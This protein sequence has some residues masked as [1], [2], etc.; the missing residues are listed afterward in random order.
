MNTQPEISQL[1]WSEDQI[2][3]GVFAALE[4]RL[5]GLEPNYSFRLGRDRWVLAAL[6][7]GAGL[8]S[9]SR[10]WASNL[11]PW[12]SFVGFSLELCAL[13]VFAYRQFWDIVPDFVDAKQ[14]YA[15]ELDH[16]FK[17][18]EEIRNWLRT[19]PHGVL[20]KRIDYLESRRESMGQRY[21]I[22]FGAADRLGLLPV[23]VGVFLQ[24]QALKDVSVLMGVFAVFVIALYGMALW[25]SRFRL[26][27]ESYIRLLKSVS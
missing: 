8:V 9:T 21:P 12:V 6:V 14:K 22:L 10:L 24:I 16:H 15:S 26:Q 27:L 7:V 2:S 20:E 13:S 19:L 18:Y 5:S 25:M 23:L 4:R 11:F 1:E 3:A 17:G